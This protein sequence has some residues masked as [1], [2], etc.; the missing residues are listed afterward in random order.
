MKIRAYLFLL[1]FFCIQ[2]V[3]PQ[4][5]KGMIAD[6]ETEQPLAGATIYFDGTTTA[7][8]A[9]EQG[10]FGISV[11]AG[12]SDLVISFVGYATYRLRKPLDYA[13]KFMKIYLEKTQTA[14]EEVVVSRGPFSR[15]QLLD[16]FRRQ[17]LG[18]SQAGKSCKILNEDDIDVSYD[19]ETN[20]LKASAA[21]TLRIRNDYLKYEIRFDLIE[22]S[23]S[24]TET[25]ISDHAINRSYYAG[26]TFYIDLSKKGEAD[27]KR[28]QTYLGS[29]PHLMHTF[30]HN[31]W[32]KQKMSL[33]TANA[34][35]NPAFYFQISDTLNMKKLRV[36]KKPG[37]AI[38][39]RDGK[40]TTVKEYFR[41]VYDK[42]HIS[43][44]DFT[45]P[46]ILIDENG[47]YL[48]ISGV[49]FGGYLGSRKAGDLL[50]RDYYQVV[51]DII[52]K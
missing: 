27:K 39:V 4:A 32:E 48:P 31:D 40:A 33:Y 24:Y 46:E 26:S 8:V 12:E 2:P 5:L 42:D 18:T 1:V 51:K 11:G 20:T 6:K 30:T 22:F 28:L 44:I 7:T 38:T 10:N 29:A 50:P 43:V 19:L 14:L 35:I 47:N 21:N 15:S 37:T 41:I 13:G 34:R 17:F 25:S 36:L 23:L 9:D 49:L 3:Q 16:V 45:R 52:N